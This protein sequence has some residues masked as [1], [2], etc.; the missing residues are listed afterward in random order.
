M[1]AVVPSVGDLICVGSSEWY[2]INNGGT[3]RVAEQFVRGLLSLV[4]RG[5]A[6]TFFGGNPSDRKRGVFSTSGGPF[7]GID[8]KR[9]SGIVHLGTVDDRFWT[10]KDTPRAGGGIDVMINVNVWWLPVL[11]C[12]HYREQLSYGYEEPIADPPSVPHRF[13]FVHGSVRPIWDIAKVEAA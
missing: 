7:H 2:G 3:L 6:S 5:K 13:D 9:L 11:E 4:P 8:P 10:W 1:S 12:D